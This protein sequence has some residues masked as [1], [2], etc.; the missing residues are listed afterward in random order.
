[1][2]KGVPVTG[3]HLALA[4]NA[5]A[6]PHFDV[7]EVGHPMYVA[8][9]EADTAF[10]SLVPREA[11]LDYLL[12]VD[13]PRSYLNKEAE[14]K[15]DL[16]NVRFG[17]LPLAVY[18]NPTER[19]NLNCSYCYLPA[20][21]RRSGIDMPA[22]RLLEALGR[23][24]DFFR[25]LLPP[26]VLPQLVFHGSE[27][28]LVREAVFQGI[29]AFSRSFRFGVQTNAT[30][31]DREALQFLVSREV[32]LGLSLD[33]AVA[34]VADR[35]RR[36]WG[37]SGVFP[38]VVRVLEELGDYP[39]L[40]VIV[41]V[42]RENLEHL[43]ALVAFLHERGVTNALFNPVRGTQPGGRELMPSA[44]ELAP[45]FFT[46]LEQAAKLYE[47]TGRQ[48]V[49]GNFANLLLALVAPS[50]RRLMCD[51]SP[52]GGGR[53]FFAVAASGEVLPCSEFLGFPQFS[54]GN[55]FDTPL[56][57]ILESPPFRQIKTRRVEDFSPC[58]RCAVRHFC[59][60]PCPAEVFALT[61]N[62]HQ[63]PPYCQFYHLQ[64]RYAL[65]IIG[66]GRLEA[67]LWKGWQEGLKEV[68]VL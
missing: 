68:R 48:L 26:E 62:L 36:T 16:D 47:K 66:E 55:L 44:E 34:E 28:L 11:V 18:F 58:H 35:T 33:G 64:A 29:E 9:I 63:P 67:F 61:G 6:G 46:A 5:G 1:M 50:A 17:L 56:G 39:H 25:S 4:V 45:A 59:G 31:L 8:L 2:A 14:L 41:T 23:L 30:L 38:Q 49:V 60:A 54:G 40:N 42:T 15:K 24:E 13:L 52:C 20:S 57:E 32:S 10:F 12:G 27:P 7:L 53:T 19:C 43:P 22:P 51:I 37:G 3:A 21:Q 65:K